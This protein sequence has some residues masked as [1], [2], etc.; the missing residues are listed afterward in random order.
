MT[1]IV[2]FAKQPV[3]G[4]VK[5]RLIPAL[6][7][8]GAARLAAEML[9]ETVNEALATGWEVE[10][11]GEPDPAGWYDGP[12]LRL[13]P[14]GA[15][16]LGE[17]LAQA[18]RQTLE[19]A[20]SILLIGTDCPELDRSRLAAAAAALGPCDAVIH[21]AEDGGYAL[22]G[23]TRFSP[24]LFDDMPWSTAEVFEET[25]ARIEALGWSLRIGDTLRDIDEPEDL[26]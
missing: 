14:Q 20:A 7:A 17:R 19:E 22:L 21:P 25:R 2:I 12:T 13:R 26:R 9:F 6:G 11:W 3:P 8:E 1:R 15:G 24:T 10:L 16:G 5:T 23:L 4:R 18:T